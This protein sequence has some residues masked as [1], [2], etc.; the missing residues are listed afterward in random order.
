MEWIE[1]GERMPESGDDVL[2]C[3][4]G[5]IVDVCM[6]LSDQFY[7]YPQVTH[8]MPLPPPPVD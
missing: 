1:C 2:I 7:G 4:P 3:T 6:Y 8:W 5:K